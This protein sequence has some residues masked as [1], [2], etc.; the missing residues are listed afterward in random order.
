MKIEFEFTDGSIAQYEVSD[1][2][3]A[4][5]LVNAD[6]RADILSAWRDEEP[7]FGLCTD[8]KEGTP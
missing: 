5:E 1:V 6:D 3:E 8:M 4:W 7:W 2:N